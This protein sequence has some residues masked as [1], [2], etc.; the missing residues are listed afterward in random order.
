MLLLLA[1]TVTAILFSAVFLWGR[2]DEN[3]IRWRL[4]RPFPY[5]DAVRNR[6][7]DMQKEDLCFV[8][9]K[10]NRNITV[11]NPEFGRSECMDVYGIAGDPAALFS[12]ANVLWPG[13]E[14]HCLLS[15][16]AAHKLFGSTDVA[17]KS[18]CI[19]DKSYEVAGVQ[20]EQENLCV[21]QL[22]PEDRQKVNFAACWYKEKNEKYM[23]KKR[24]TSLFSD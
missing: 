10:K 3:R 19:G 15:A 16:D 24:V 9:W 22:S 12:G 1:M 7:L 21:Y 17:G 2:A 23:M 6:I 8:F 4:E 13:E 5:D 14:G 18:V 20:H 11:E